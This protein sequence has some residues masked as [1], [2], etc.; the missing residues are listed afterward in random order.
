MGPDYLTLVTEKGHKYLAFYPKQNDGTPLK[1]LGF[2]PAKDEGFVYW[3]K[4]YHPAL[5]KQVYRIF[6]NTELNPY[7][8]EQYANW[9]IYDNYQ[10]Y[11]DFDIVSDNNLKPWQP[12]ACKFLANRKRAFLALAPGLGKTLSALRAAEAAGYKRIVVIAPLSLLDN[13]RAEI[14]HW[15]PNSNT[16]IFR[17]NEYHTQRAK[18]ARR[19]FCIMSYE[20]A[21][22]WF[23]ALQDH[24]PVDLVI[25]DESILIKN[26]ETIRFA[27]AP[28]RKTKVG[29]KPAVDGISKLMADH[30]GAIWM[31]SGGPT[32][33]Y[34]DDMWA[35][36]YL[37]DRKRF[38]SYWQFASTYCVVENTQWGDKIIGN[39]P[40][41]YDNLRKDIDDI[42]YARSQ[43]EVGA[44]LP[45]FLEETIEIEMAE[46][47]AKAYKEMEDKFFAELPS[48]DVII[49]ANLLTQMLRLNQI[50]SN[51]SLLEEK[52]Y[53]T[54]SPLWDAAGEM[55]EYVEK[56]VILWTNFIETAERLAINLGGKYSVALLNGKV[57]VPD[58]QAIADN[59]QAGRINILIAHPGV[60]KYG[61][62]L[63]KARTAI[64]LERSFSGD[65]FYQSLYRIRRIGTTQRP[66]VIYLLSTRGGKRTVHHAIHDVLK[67]KHDAN[68]QAIT[69]DALRAAWR[70]GE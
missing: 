1:E 29:T 21:L 7:L 5:I 46:A 63:T 33:R 66:H 24:S 39:K 3:R 58:R 42:F 43:D 18:N 54:S 15:L 16:A 49:T 47:Q 2:K 32:S 65:D 64:Y 69:A 50:A 19:I 28:E 60:G 11:N 68:I 53:R 70:K 34:L 62:T 23:K 57:P 55:L 20:G 14:N 37:L 9:K 56:P 25:F 31:L 17:G 22:R 67:A 59:F 48:G 30:K 6:P 52:L 26:R 8:A 36:L 61:F 41:A 12:S 13:W 27:G 38:S 4:S 35:Q 44:E 10:T 45:E 40:G 51:L